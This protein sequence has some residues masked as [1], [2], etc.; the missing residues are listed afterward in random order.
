MPLILPTTLLKSLLAAGAIAAC[1]AVQ[2]AP[3]TI[4]YAGVGARMVGQ[5]TNLSGST[6]GLGGA[7]PRAGYRVDLIVDNGGD[8]A[9]NQ[10][11]TPTD[12]RCVVWTMRRNGNT[13]F[14]QVVTSANPITKGS[15]SIQTNASGALQQV[16]TTLAQSDYAM[17]GTYTIV[18]PPIAQP[19]PSAVPDGY[20]NWFIPNAAT[21]SELA[22]YTGV[23]YV[24]AQDPLEVFGFDQESTP[25][26]GTGGGEISTGSNVSNWSA[27]I[28]APTDMQCAGKPLPPS[29]PDNPGTGGAAATPVPSLG[30]G[31]ILA[32][33]LG[34]ASIGAL[35]LRRRKA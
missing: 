4:S 26:S 1:T 9:N 25:G 14:S 6:S 13:V 17:P 20:F 12:V 5:G 23:F 33:G 18:D 2:A 27:P 32:L 11:W 35:R 16:F 7:D 21:T 29:K 3:F 19:G 22:N 10:T 34:A 8:S 15:G 28:P 24:V 30:T 31:A